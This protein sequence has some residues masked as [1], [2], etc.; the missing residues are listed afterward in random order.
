MRAKD[1]RELLRENPDGLSLSDIQKHFN[2]DIE[3]VRKLVKNLPDAYL[4]RWEEAPRM[5]YRAI[6]CVV[7]PPPDCPHPNA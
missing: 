2:A 6:Y 3:N 7:I 4:D 1:V 5:Q